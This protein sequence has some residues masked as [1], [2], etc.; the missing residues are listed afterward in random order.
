MSSKKKPN[1]Q[2]NAS[3]SLKATIYRTERSHKH[4]HIPF[5]YA[6]EKW[7]PWTTRLEPWVE[8]L[9]LLGRKH[10]H[11][12][13]HSPKGFF[14]T[15]PSQHY[16]LI[17]ITQGHSTLTKYTRW[18]NKQHFASTLLS[19]NSTKPFIKLIKRNFSHKYIFK[20]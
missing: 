4:N 13:F 10:F 11:V 3:N 6:G 17:L 20:V 9:P 16:S 5:I 14:F 1:S 12:P 18:L 7:W 8:L 2:K 19:P 15:T